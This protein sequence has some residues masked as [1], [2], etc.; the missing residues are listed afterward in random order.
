M[1]LEKIRREDGQGDEQQAK[2]GSD[3]EFA[4]IPVHRIEPIFVGAI[5]GIR[6]GPPDLKVGPTSET[7]TRPE[8]RAYFLPQ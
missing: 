4:R 3:G 2:D 7:V 8:G 5:V 1:R 6:A